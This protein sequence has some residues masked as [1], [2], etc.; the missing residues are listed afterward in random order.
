MTIDF[1]A[2]YD[3]NLDIDYQ[4]IAYNVINGAL[5]YEKFPYESYVSL[6]LVDNASIHSIN[7]EFRETDRATDVLSFPMVDY[8]TYG[9]NDFLEDREDCFDTESGELVLGDIVVSLDKVKEQAEAYGHSY[10]REYAFLIAHSMLHLMGYDHMEAE[11]AVIMEKKQAE[12]LAG[13]GI[14]R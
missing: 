1:T 2:E 3:L 14:N 4:Q 6:S 11:E 7:R 5:D 8:D 9:E 13:L 10:L 12:I